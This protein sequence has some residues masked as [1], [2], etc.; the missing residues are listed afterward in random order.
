MS[1]F[2]QTIEDQSDKIKHLKQKNKI[3]QDENK[4]KI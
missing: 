4:S 3:L 2:N 1:S